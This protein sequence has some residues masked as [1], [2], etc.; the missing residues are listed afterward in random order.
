MARKRKRKGCKTTLRNCLKRAK[1]K[2]AR[3][4]CLGKFSRCKRRRR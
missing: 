3:G 4:K 2:R 1:G